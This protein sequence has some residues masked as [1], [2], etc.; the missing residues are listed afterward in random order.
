MMGIESGL[1]LLCL[2]QAWYRTGP[3]R[4]CGDEF[5]YRILG[6]S[7]LGPAIQPGVIQPGVMIFRALIACFG[8]SV[9]RA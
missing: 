4:N 7:I 9:S 6:L 1:S 5:K 8:S 3:P 2:S